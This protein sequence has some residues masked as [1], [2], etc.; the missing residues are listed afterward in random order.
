VEISDGT[1]TESFSDMKLLSN[2]VNDGKSWFV[3]GEKSAQEKATEKLYKALAANTE[4]I[5][6]VQMA[7][8]ELSILLANAITPTGE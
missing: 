7:L 5:S 4:N 8:A 6:D 2:R 1:T 3:L